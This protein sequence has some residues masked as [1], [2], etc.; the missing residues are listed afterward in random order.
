MS[1]AEVA[2]ALTSQ[3]TLMF[4]TGVLPRSYVLDEVL[5]SVLDMRV[6]LQVMAAVAH[7][8]TPIEVSDDELARVSM[9]W[10]GHGSLFSEFDAAFDLDSLQPYRHEPSIVIHSRE[11]PLWDRP[12]TRIDIVHNARTAGGVSDDVATSRVR[13]RAVLERGVWE[14]V[15]ETVFVEPAGAAV[16]A[17]RVFEGARRQGITVRTIGD[18]AQDVELPGYLDAW[19][20]EAVARDLEQGYV[21]VLPE[22]SPDGFETPAWW[23]VDRSS[24]ETLGRIG[25][26]IGGARAFGASPAERRVLSPDSTTAPRA[27]GTP[28]PAPGQYMV[29][30]AY[31]V[32]RLPGTTAREYGIVMTV[33]SAALLAL[34]GTSICM[35]WVYVRGRDV[36]NVFTC[37]GLAVGAVMLPFSPVLGFA[38]ASVVALIDIE[39]DFEAPNDPCPPNSICRPPGE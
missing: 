39:V 18:A 4:A 35:T 2:R 8:R 19:T 25:P 16:N 14:T 3:H 32:V 6:P 33:A 29:P 13:A 27:Q 21:V 11:L 10:S 20:S 24:G 23:R 15:V 30:S 28:F 22:R 9:A 7:D 17:V 38:L 36:N 26:G 5:A 37:M 12:E 31:N 1:R 34:I